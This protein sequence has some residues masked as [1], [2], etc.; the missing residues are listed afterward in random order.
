MACVPVADK[1]ASIEMAGPAV[2]A[3]ATRLIVAVP[4]M[5]LLAV[6]V[7]VIVTVVGAG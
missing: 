2:D 4:I 1:L 7:A 6:L 3:G 5:E